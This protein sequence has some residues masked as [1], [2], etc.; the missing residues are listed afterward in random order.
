MLASGWSVV[1]DAAFL[2]A[3]ERAPF[4]ALARRGGFAFST[5]VCDAPVEVLRR[6]IEARGAAGRDASE[7]DRT[8]LDR[9]LT[10]HEPPTADE[11]AE[12]ITLSTDA[13]LE[14]VEAAC[15]ALAEQLRASA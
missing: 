5:I 8:V 2:T 3:R 14:E 11:R 10:I 12:S 7:A 1:V 4:R 13:P 15:A 6:R 9:Q